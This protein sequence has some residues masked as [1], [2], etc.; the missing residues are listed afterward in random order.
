[1]S[2]GGS[3]GA[4]AGA[5]AV[6]SGRGSTDRPLGASTARAVV[7]RS[8]L[9]AVRSRRLCPATAVGLV[10]EADPAP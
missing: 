4:S 1:M 7:R 5:A 6:Q 3:A 8:L 2:K 10:S 9:L